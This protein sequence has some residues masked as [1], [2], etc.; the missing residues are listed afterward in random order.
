MKSIISNEE[1]CWL[2]KTTKNLHR[3]HI[4]SGNGRREKSE[5]LGL[6]LYLCAYHHNASSVAVHN[7]KAF[8]LT[9]RKL[10]Q[11]EFE[12]QIG[13]REEFIKIFGRSWL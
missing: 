3:H 10:G 4:Y 6:W 9:L 7:N 12:K 2:C 1:C 5:E 11:E 13:T 8:D